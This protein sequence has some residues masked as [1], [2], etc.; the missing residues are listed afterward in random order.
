MLA[1]ENG[2]TYSAAVIVQVRS[3]A[4]G[5]ALQIKPAA[6]TPSGLACPPGCGASLAFTRVDGKPALRCAPGQARLA[7]RAAA[8]SIGGPTMRPWPAQ[9]AAIRSGSGG[10]CCR[11]K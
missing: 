2:S 10:P 4:V 7:A 8:T 3:V 6:V 5:A 11:A 9:M 1:P